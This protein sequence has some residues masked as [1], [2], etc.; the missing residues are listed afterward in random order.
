M[1][2]PEHPEK[3]HTALE[4]LVLK[5]MSRGKCASGEGGWVDGWAACAPES[6]DRSLNQACVSGDKT[7]DY[8]SKAPSLQELLL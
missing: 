3:T 4:S 2:E 5:T 1:E 8:L 6:S 7:D